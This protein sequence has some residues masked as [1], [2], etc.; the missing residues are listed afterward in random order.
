VVHVASFAETRHRMAGRRA[1]LDAIARGA[2]GWFDPDIAALFVRRGAELLAEVEH[3]SVWDVVLAIEPLPRRFL[4]PAGV[5][6]LALAF[7]DLVDMKSSYRLG[8]SSGVAQLTERACG[9]LGMSNEAIAT[10]RR[11]ALLHD[12]GM[13]SVP[14][15]ILDKEGKL[16]SAEWE[17]VRLHAYHTERVLARSPALAGIA[18]LASLHHERLDGSGYHRGVHAGTQPMA[19]RV[20]AAADVFQALTEPRPHRPLR[21]PE[22]AA[23]V[24]ASEVSRGRLDPQAARAVCDAAG[25]PIARGRAA[26]DTEGT[27]ALSRREIEVLR[28]LARGQSNKQIG[29]ALFIAPGTVHTHVMHIYD[30][31][32]VSSRPTATLLALERGLLFD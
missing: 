12:L 17:R 2:R 25:A 29:R 28:L 31:L 1:A 22:A 16:T 9:A 26:K 14:T 11:A 21:S 32:G 20:I 15:G 3:E 4:E 7:A 24:V 8:H 5:D 10:A 23:K 30:K 19:A 27:A 6:A 18:E 13:Y